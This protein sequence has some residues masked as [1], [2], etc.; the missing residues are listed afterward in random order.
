[1]IVGEQDAL[2]PPSEAQAMSQGISGS[3]VTVIPGAAHLSNL[4]NP[5]AFN[6]AVLGLIGQG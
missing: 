3:R 6:A 2:T 1:V 4:E 5:E